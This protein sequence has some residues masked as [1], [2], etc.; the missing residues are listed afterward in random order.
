MKPVLPHRDFGLASGTGSDTGTGSHGGPWPAR[1]D[2]PL[3]ENGATDG[4]VERDAASAAAASFMIDAERGLIVAADPAAWAAWGLDAAAAAPPVAMDRAMPALQK[5]AQL[6]GRRNVVASEPLTFWSSGGIKHWRC[7]VQRAAAGQGLFVVQV[8]DPENDAAP[9]I[10][11][12]PGPASQ[13]G[14]RESVGQGLEPRAC[15]PMPKDV[16]AAAKLAHELRTPL[17]AAIA[18]A[19]VL[20]DEHFG[21]LGNARYRDYA[22][23]IYDSARHALG[24]VDGMLAA[25][26]TASGLPELAFADLDPAAIVENC[27]AVTRPLAQQ[28]GLELA[29]E[30]GPRTPRIVAD[31]V[32]LKQMLLNLITNA[33]KFAGAGDRITVGMTY[34]PGGPLRIAVAD[35]GPGMPEPPLALEG[36]KTG[37]G[38][39]DVG[40]A[41]RGAVRTAG[42]GIGLPLTRALAEANGAQ[43]VID[44]APG[45]GTRVTIAFGKDRVVPV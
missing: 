39:S 36:G 41:G 12:E 31:E 9:M 19:E 32:S 7:K 44:S 26:P 42:L 3:P 15:A 16:S 25:N 40:D 10:E 28:A 20:K 2:E 33:I 38:G 29:A 13:M 14:G 35:T 1:R 21:R 8:L 11:R 27:L 30:F 22:R 43:L 37:N 4:L 18:Y 45:R 34:E 17:A 23:N 5:L 6:A 24:V